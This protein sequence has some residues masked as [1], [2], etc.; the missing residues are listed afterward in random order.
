MKTSPPGSNSPPIHEEVC[1]RFET[2][3]PWL[4][5]APLATPVVPPVYWRNATSSRPVPG[6]LE[7]LA[8][9][10]VE[11]SKERDRARQVERRHH[12]LHPPHHEVDERGLREAET[13]PHPHEH[14]VLH[15][16]AGHHPGEHAREV[17]DD[18]DGPSPRVIELVLELA[19]RVERV[20]V[21]H[22]EAREQNP[23]D[24]DGVRVEV[25]HHDR[26]PVPALETEPLQVGG[27]RPRP[28]V[29]LAEGH[30]DPETRVGRALGIA[31]DALLE[32]GH[33]RVVGVDVRLGGDT[34][35]IALQPDLVHR[36]LPRWPKPFPDIR[37]HRAAA[38][39]RR[40]AAPIPP[41]FLGKCV[42]MPR[43]PDARPGARAG[44]T[45]P[46]PGARHRAPPRRM[47]RLQRVRP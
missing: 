41:G 6:R 12:L 11:G 30:R 23:E 40:R 20:R 45:R 14:H 22:R 26:D 42:Q 46:G 5:A 47:R 25:R 18:H 39:K 34:L 1:W 37:H 9:A 31:P 17:L 4:R 13:V 16:R 33:D 38:G 8:A 35:R 32:Q 3:L 36:S 21:D 43:W 19:R 24:R 28:F 10:L 27:E 2:T 15:P 7:R 29:E 44:S